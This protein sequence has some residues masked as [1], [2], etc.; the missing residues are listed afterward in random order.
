MDNIEGEERATKKKKRDLLNK[1]RVIPLVELK[2]RRNRHKESSNTEGNQPT[3]LS[4][5]SSPYPSS[6]SSPKSLISKEEARFE[7]E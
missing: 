5:S 7:R 2:H 3:T 6:S 4:S 1:V